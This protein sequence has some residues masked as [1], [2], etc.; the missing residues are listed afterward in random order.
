MSGDALRPASTRAFYGQITL[1][2]WAPRRGG[3]G[4]GSARAAALPCSAGPR[5]SRSARAATALRRGASCS[6]PE[7]CASRRACFRCGAS[8]RPRRRAPCARPAPALA[9]LRASARAATQASLP[10]QHW[11]GTGSRKRARP[12]DLTE[13]LVP[14]S[15]RGLLAARRGPRPR[16]ARR[17][18]GRQWQAGRRCQPRRPPRDLRLER[19]SAIA[20]SE[21]RA[22][23][24]STTQSGCCRDGVRRAAPA[25]GGR[26]E[27]PRRG[28]CSGRAAAGAGV[29]VTR[30]PRWRRAHWLRGCPGWRVGGGPSAARRDH[31][32]RSEKPLLCPPLVTCGW[33]GSARGG[34]RR[35]ARTDARPDVRRDASGGGARPA[36]GGPRRGGGGAQQGWRARGPG[37]AQARC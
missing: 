18:P 37:V 6:A 30:W 22:R 7:G 5:A 35:G 36:A 14:R 29:W 21:R 33:R 26:A 10:P 15:R 3:G 19:R 1:K 2:C 32:A 31:A 34:A 8:T 25:A 12:Q 13:G 27:A 23:P 17:Q 4:E 20:A 24:S 11:H 16:R 28:R 9:P